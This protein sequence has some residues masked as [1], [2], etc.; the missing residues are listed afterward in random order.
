MSEQESSTIPPFFNRL[1]SGVLRSPLHRVA[2]RS[3]LLI[4]FSGRK[5]GKTYTTPIS[6]LREG[7]MV[8]AFSHARWTKNLAG[9]AP[10][11]LNIK[12]KAYRGQADLVTDDKE[13]IAR[14]LQRFLNIVRSDARFY[15]VKFDEDGTPNWED[16]QRAAQ[17]SYLLKIE[18]DG[19]E[20]PRP[21]G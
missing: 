20:L 7:N 12:N 3:V 2:S 18:L 19:Q 14:E 21:S 4:T 10:V 15:Q 1:M 17:T 8:T 5:S 16:V 6:Y 11:T 13:V 9:G